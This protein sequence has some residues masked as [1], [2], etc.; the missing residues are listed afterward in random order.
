MCTGF[1]GN[2]HFRTLSR[3][4]EIVYSLTLCMRHTIAGMIS[5]TDD[6]SVLNNNRANKWIRIY[7]SNTQLCKLD[8]AF[9]KLQFVAHNRSFPPPGRAA[10]PI[11]SPIYL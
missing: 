2:I 5:F 1:H 6:P 8:R 7:S 3:F 9:H 4:G 10:L 11:A